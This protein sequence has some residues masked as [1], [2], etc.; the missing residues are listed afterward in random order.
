MPVEEHRAG[1][2]LRTPQDIAA[3]LDAAIKE[4]VSLQVV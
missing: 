2:Y 4:V 3:Y 1:D